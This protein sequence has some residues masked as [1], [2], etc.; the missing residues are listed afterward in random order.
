VPFVV[1]SGLSD[2]T[3]AFTAVRQG[4]QDYLFKNEINSNQLLRAIRYATERKRAELALEAERKKLY[5][6]LNSLPAYVYLKKA[7]LGIHFA[8]R[9]FTEVFGEPG[10]RHCYEVLWDRSEPCENCRT[11]EV[12]RTKT[13]Q[14]GEWTSPR[15]GRTYEV[16]NYPFCTDDDLLVLTLGLDITER[17]QAEE[18]IKD[19]EEQL[20]AIYENAP[21]IMMLVDGERCVRKVNR[22]AEQFAGAAEADLIGRRGGEALRCLHALD[23]PQGCGFGPYCQECTVRRTVIE[24]FEIG[25]CHHQVEACLPFALEGKHQDVTFLLNTARLAVRGQPQVLVTIQ[26]ITERKEAEEKLRVSERELRFLASQLLTA[27]ERERE[28][29]SRELHDELGQSLL[30]LKLQAAQIEKRLDQDQTG[31]KKDCQALMHQFDRLVGEVRRLARDLSP[32]MVRDLGL[33]S[34]L[35]RLIEDFSLHYGIQAEIDMIDGL[36]RLFSRE[37]QINIYRIFQ[38]SLTNIGKYADASQLSVAIRRTDGCV[39][40]QIADNGRGFRLE[41]VWGRGPSRRG[42]G[43]MSMEERARMLGGTLKIKSREGQ[44]T[45]LVLMIPVSNSQAG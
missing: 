27:Q 14:K 28:R 20:T 32:T 17:K 30:V 39:S 12:L 37:A 45:Q 40:C 41:E 6:L 11:R 42:L 7:D 38:E 18:A 4:A 2:E 25:H 31:I 36:D 23:N 44:G 15:N 8:N 19:R 10:N 9:R 34:A 1:L 29:I 3:L 33:A 24:T 21:L 16:Y 22:L 13:P 26:D 35:K 5:T 43:L